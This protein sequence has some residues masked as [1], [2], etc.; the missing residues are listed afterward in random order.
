MFKSKICT[1]L[2]FLS[3]IF[4]VFQIESMNRSSSKSSNEDDSKSELFVYHISDGEKCVI[5]ENEIT[6]AMDCYLTTKHP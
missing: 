1:I 2:L 3:F 4:F 6:I 5:Y